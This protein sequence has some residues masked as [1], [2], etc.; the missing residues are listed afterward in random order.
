MPKRILRVLC[1]VDFQC[2]SEGKMGTPPH[3]AVAFSFTYFGSIAEM[4]KAAD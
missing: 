3:N 2:I 4:V 1:G